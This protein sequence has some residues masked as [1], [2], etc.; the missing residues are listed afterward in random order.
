MSQAP[1]LDPGGNTVE[2]ASSI[3]MDRYELSHHR[4]LGL[5]TRLAHHHKVD[6]R[7]V[8]AAVVAAAIARRNAQR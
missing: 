6:L 7:V 8:A 3:A 2:Q 5:L 4:A 1:D